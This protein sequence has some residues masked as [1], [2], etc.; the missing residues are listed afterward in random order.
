[1]KL[2]KPVIPS[3]AF[4]RNQGIY[5]NF[6]NK[7]ADSTICLASGSHRMIKICAKIQYAYEQ[8]DG[9]RV[10]GVTNPPR[11]GGRFRQTHGESPAR[12][13]SSLYYT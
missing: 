1:M 11:C 3:K 8:Q 9:I 6:V 4:F 2:P 7:K 5:A 12:K 13:Q 10:A